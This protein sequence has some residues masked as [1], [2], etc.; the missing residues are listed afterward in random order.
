MGNIR[1]RRLENDLRQVQQLPRLTANRVQFS[2]EGEPPTRY[3]VTYRVKGLVGRSVEDIREQTRFDVEFQLTD[4]YPKTAPV[5]TARQRVW[6]PNFWRNQ[7]VC[8]DAEHF[9]A[10]QSLSELV[11]RVGE[12]I[13][14]QVYNLSDPANRDA[15]E[16]VLGNEHRF[17]IDKETLQ[18][19]A[20]PDHDDIVIQFADDDDD[21]FEVSIG[22]FSRSDA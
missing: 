7:K 21:D 2:S 5:V 18:C 8:I 11:V 4:E 19:G 3:V 10:S 13:Q 9:A 6:H 22:A 16:W 14:Y 15:A 17:P 20:P 12:M 1:I